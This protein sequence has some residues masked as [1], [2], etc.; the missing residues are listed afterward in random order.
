MYYSILEYSLYSIYI[1]VRNRENEVLAKIY[2]VTLLNAV[3][4]LFN[5]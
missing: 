2:E 4:T 1:E 5:I 3:E